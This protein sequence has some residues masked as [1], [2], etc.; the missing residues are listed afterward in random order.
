MYI[1]NPQYACTMQGSRYNYSVRTNLLSSL[2]ST[3]LVATAK[4]K[5]YGVLM[6]FSRF[7][8]SG[9]QLLKMFYSKFDTD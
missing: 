9:F 2:V 3:T 8:M 7:V 1:I 6:A 5:C 4:E